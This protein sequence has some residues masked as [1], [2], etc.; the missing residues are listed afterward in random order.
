[1]EKIIIPFGWYDVLEII[2]TASVFIG[3]WE[4]ANHDGYFNW[5]NFKKGI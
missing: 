4:Y 1:M 2:I 3:L 5:E